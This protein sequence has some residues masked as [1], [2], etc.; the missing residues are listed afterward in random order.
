MQSA[1]ETQ[2]GTSGETGTQEPTPKKT[3]VKKPLEEKG[4][5]E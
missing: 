5:I 3:V 4:Y 2:E 1:E